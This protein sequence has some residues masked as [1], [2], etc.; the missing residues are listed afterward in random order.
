MLSFGGLAFLNPWLLVALAA[1]PALWWLLRATPP[2]PKRFAFPGVR[3]L[4]GLDDQERMP[5]KTPWWL[6]LLRCMVAGLAIL[7]FAEPL[8][9]PRA[10]LSGSGPLLLLMDGG[11]ASAPDWDA[12]RARALETLAQAERADRPAAFVSMARLPA[13]D[14]PLALRPA[15]DWRGEIEAALP[16]PW[17]PQRAETAA[18][19]AGAG[20]AETVWITDGL[21][22]DDA[23][24]EALGAALAALGPLAVIG[25]DA[26]A[27]ALRAPALEDGAL[28]VDALRAEAG[29]PQTM[30]IAAFART[31]SGPSRRI[32][33]ADATFGVDDLSAT[34]AFDLPLELRNQVERLEIVG[35]DSAAAVS[36][37]DEGVRRRRAGLVSGGTSTEAQRLVSD[38]HYL[39]AALAERAEVVEGDVAEVL[40]A[41]PDVLFLA[42]VGRFTD[43]ETEALLGFVDKG[44]LLV[45]FA[46]PRLARGADALNS[47]TGVVESPLLPVPL[48]AGGRA[49]GGA[50]AWS[51]PQR[52]RPFAEGTPFAGLEAPEDVSVSRQILAQLGPDLGERTWAALA[53]GTPLVTAAER[54]AGRVVL[55]H[56]TANAEWSNLPLSGLFV[57][58][59]QRL[60]QFAGGGGAT[61]RSALEGLSA[62][63]VALLDGFGRLHEA[64]A[65]GVPVSRLETAPGPDAGPGVYAAGETQIAFN[66]HGPDAALAPLVAPPGAATERLGGGDE[67]PLAPWLLA[68]AVLLLAADT[69][70]TLL[71]SGRLPMPKRRRGVAKAVGGAAA[72]LLAL[73]LVPGEARAQAPSGALETVFAHVLT[74][75]ARADEIARAGL[76][77]LSAVLTARTAI[78]PAEPVGLDLETDDLSFYPILYWPIVENQPTPSDVAIAKLNAFMRSGGMIVFDTR[79]R[80]LDIGG[81]AGASPNARALRRVASRLDLPPLEAVPSDHVLTRAFYLLEEFPG[82][83]SGGRVWVEAAADPEA[84]AEEGAPFRNLNDGVSPVVVGSVDW[85]GA[86]A[87]DDRGAF[88]APVT[89]AGGWRQRE[90]AYRF[91]INLAMYALTG[92]YKSDQVHVPALLERLGQ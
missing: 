70:A 64:E 61:D 3:L 29:A 88:M 84:V 4:L 8:M 17:A 20:F 7:A 50:M 34:A 18:L 76:A 91:G 67:R 92:N 53:D 75:D 41:R 10:Q 80:H 2:S 19:L 90:M 12:R 62:R 71:L 63:P 69:V 43:A 21:A 39:R 1:L 79:D 48:R 47:P 44:G 13:G 85:A 83:F 55:F 11:A 77:G 52:I 87:V 35:A 73:A 56:V 32:G 72:L 45:R 60:L 66:L 26:P 9:N 49:V 89:G 33:Q 46:G 15:A 65:P 28:T 36:L 40:E 27:P 25:P 68:L 23:A 59:V 78:E 30:T 57:N 42:D 82:R 51:Q 14:A 37:A 24:T 16:A 58:M 74:G 54:G 86:W 22:H 5:E 31:E 38:L 6:L 81:G